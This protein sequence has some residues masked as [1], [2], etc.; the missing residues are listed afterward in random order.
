M[1]FSHLLVSLFLMAALGVSLQVSAV[2]S[3]SP[4]PLAGVRT[5]V[6]QVPLLRGGFSQEKQVAGFRNPLRSSGRFVLARE[7]GVIWTTV[8]PFPSEIVITRDRIV[9]R[10]RDGSA[11]VEVDGRQ[12][13]GL[14]TVNAM[15]FAL[16]SGD[17]KALTTTF[18]VKSEPADGKGWR[19]TLLPRSRQLAQAFTSVRL[20]G[21]RYVREV[22]LREANGDVT[23]IRFDGMSETP[24]TLTREEAGR[25]D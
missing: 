9:S 22:E 23:R 2:N 3:Q 5:Q 4:D 18:E 12:Q 24:A 11:R 13:P 14:R 20:A 10:Q 21:D 6:A 8:A 15:M 1:K 17:M 19:M 16:M 25:F 7:K